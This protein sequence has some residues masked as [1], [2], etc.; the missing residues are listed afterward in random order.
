MDRTLLWFLCCKN[1]DEENKLLLLAVWW[2]TP[3]LVF[4]WKTPFLLRFDWKSW[5]FRC[6]WR[7]FPFLVLA[8]R[9][10][11]QAR[12]SIEVKC[13]FLL[14]F[15]GHSSQKGL[16][17]RVNKKWGRESWR[18]VEDGW[19]DVWCNDV[20]CNDVWGRGGFSMVFEVDL[21]LTSLSLSKRRGEIWGE[22]C[23]FI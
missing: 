3:F 22:N 10:K 16:G 14:R 8:Q 17:P 1:P 12:N 6:C 2:K 9:S 11:R 21:Y 20:W 4:V 5:L 19:S 13:F 7:W 15:K 18:S 23:I